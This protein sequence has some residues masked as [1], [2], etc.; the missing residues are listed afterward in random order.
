[1]GGLKRKEDYEH[2]RRD[3]VGGLKKMKNKNE[4]N[5][6]KRKDQR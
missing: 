2:P 4:K 3:G 1:V 5:L 6:L